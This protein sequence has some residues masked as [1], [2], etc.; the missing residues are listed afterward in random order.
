MF[1]LHSDDPVKNS[2]AEL[3]TRFGV[4]PIRVDAIIKLA[5]LAAEQ[6][7][8]RLSMSIIEV[9]LLWIHY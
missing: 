3:A 1:K 7:C 5:R 2:A 6:V 9:L 4:S 8:V